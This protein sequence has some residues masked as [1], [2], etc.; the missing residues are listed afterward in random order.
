MDAE[1]ADTVMEEVTLPDVPTT[2]PN[3]GGPAAKKL[4]SA[5]EEK[6]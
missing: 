4:K 1:I 3:D 2:E 5:D 6:P